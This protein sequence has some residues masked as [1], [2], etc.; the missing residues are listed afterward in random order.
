MAVLV[1]ESLCELQ[2]VE[3][4]LLSHYDKQNQNLDQDQ[5]NDVEPAKEG[6]LSLIPRE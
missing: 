5:Q 6:P 1:L 3:R 2:Q 4:W